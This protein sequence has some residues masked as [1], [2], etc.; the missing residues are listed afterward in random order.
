MPEYTTLQPFLMKDSRQQIEAFERLFR[1]LLQQMRALF[2]LLLGSSAIV[3]VAYPAVAD[4]RARIVR[5]SALEGDVQIDRAA[6]QGFEK[7]VMNLPIVEGAKFRTGYDGFAEI[8]L[9][10][11]STVR[12]TPGSSLEISRLVLLDSG[13]KGT[14]V[15]V[16]DGVVYVN[17][18]GTKD[19]EFLLTFGDQK[20]P[21]VKSE[22]V[23]LE[24]GHSKARLS[25]LG[26][27]PLQALGP[28]SQTE[29][30]KKRAVTFAMD[31]QTPPGPET[32]VTKMQY[33]AWDEQQFQYHERY[34]KNGKYRTP[35]YAFGFSD[36]NYFGS[37]FNS[38]VCGLVWRPYLVSAS[39]DPFTNGSWVQF[40]NLGYSWVSWYPWGWMPYHSGSWQ[41]CPGYG[42][43]WQPSQTWVPLNYCVHSKRLCNPDK[44]PQ[45]AREP[46]EYTG[47]RK[48]ALSPI[49]DVI[50]ARRFLI[51]NDSAGLGIPRGSIADLKG[52]SREIQRHGPMNAVIYTSPGSV[53]DTRVIT[54]HGE[55]GQAW[56]QQGSGSQTA[57]GNNQHA[58]SGNTNSASGNNQHVNSGNTNSATGGS[59]GSQGGN[60]TPP[61]PPPRTSNPK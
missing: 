27:A 35:P 53:H 24:V 43:S 5:L 56:R 16:L 30:G 8:E 60:S 58:N 4:S 20:V 9:E 37:F 19:D 55:S 17:Y 25:V 23:R 51:R 54:V 1:F 46:A 22:H 44:H 57:V 7:A 21:L 2:I 36:L 50:R 47:S 10:D 45:P 59:H 34:A 6:G 32:S 15:N 38:S 41:M 42:W 12:F 28:S 29:I 11:G 61:P 13:A 40:P 3:M 14:T 18:E 33:D 52:V 31:G 49:P 26:G 39:W 48:P